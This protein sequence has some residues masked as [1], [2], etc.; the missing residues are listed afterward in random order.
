ML[1]HQRWEFIKETK[2]VRKQEHTLST[3]EAITKKKRK[4]GKEPSSRP[5][6]KDSRKNVKDQEER[7]KE[8]YPNF[9]VYIF[10]LVVSTND[11]NYYK[12]L[13]VKLIFFRLSFVLPVPVLA[14]F[15]LFLS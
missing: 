9:L 15:Y 11:R 8:I 14:L 7:R 6:K 4:K 10:N 5:R 1:R 2:K 12:W 3:E 13:K